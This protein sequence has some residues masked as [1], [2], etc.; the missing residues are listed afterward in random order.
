MLT[1]L[2]KALSYNP[3]TGELTWKTGYRY[4]EKV[5]GCLNTALGYWQIGFMKKRYYSHRIAWVI[6]YGIEPAFID[7]INGNRADNRICNLRSVTKAENHRNSKRFSNNT[8]GV[9]GVWP[10]ST[11]GQ[12][13]ASITINRKNIHLGCFDSLEAATAVRKAA[14]VDYSFHE[15]HGRA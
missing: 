11:P 12:W 1:D 15:N 8:S 4:A 10:T 9:T 14:E 5:A 6:Y 3:D 2:V 7:H 13:R